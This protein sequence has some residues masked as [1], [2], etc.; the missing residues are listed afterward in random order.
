[1]T[2]AIPRDTA[3]YVLPLCKALHKGK[4]YIA[5]SLANMACRQGFSARYFRISKLLMEL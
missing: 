1:M 3:I 5:V 4:T 2:A